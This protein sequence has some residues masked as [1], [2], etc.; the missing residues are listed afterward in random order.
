M[1]CFPLNNQHAKYNNAFVCTLTGGT[2]PTRS[3]ETLNAPK[4]Q[5]YNNFMVTKDAPSENALYSRKVSCFCGV[6]STGKMGPCHNSPFV[7]A[8]E[9]SILDFV[10]AQPNIPLREHESEMWRQ[11]D[12]LQNE[13]ETL[14]SYCCLAWVENVQQP[15]VLLIQHLKLN[16]RTVRCHILP[17][18]KPLLN[19]FG[20]TVVCRPERLCAHL[21]TTCDCNLLHSVNFQVKHVLEVAV[22]RVDRRHHRSLFCSTKCEEAAPA[23]CKLIHLP[24]T[25]QAN[26]CYDAYAQKRLDLFN[27]YYL[28]NIL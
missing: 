16:Q 24:A 14:P 3:M 4:S 12:L 21:Q 2:F 23:G 1:T 18:H 15:T 22:V 26:E 11:L 13:A 20:Y 10:P 25:Q 28:R 8:W 17:H 7:P 27:D 19:D 9:E 6:C 5:S